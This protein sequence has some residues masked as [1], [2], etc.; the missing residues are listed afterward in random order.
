MQTS[1]HTASLP[2]V[3]PAS[4]RRAPRPRR[5]RV[6]TPLLRVTRGPRL[7]GLLPGALL[8]L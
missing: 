3:T 7:P 8:S 2:E 5:G 6:V 1:S 4:V